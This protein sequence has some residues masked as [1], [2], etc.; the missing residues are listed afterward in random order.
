MGNRNFVFSVSVGY[1]AYGLDRQF[2]IGR[3]QKIKTL[4]TFELSPKLIINFN[5]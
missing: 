5:I 3:S 4:N 1:L 2:I